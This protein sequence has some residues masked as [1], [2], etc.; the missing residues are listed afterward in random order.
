[1]EFGVAPHSGFKTGCGI[2]YEELDE[3]GSVNG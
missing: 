3:K 2:P 1:M